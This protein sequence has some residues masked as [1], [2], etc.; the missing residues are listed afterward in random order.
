MCTLLSVSRD[1][2]MSTSEITE[3]IIKR[4]R[5]DADFNSDGF[6]LI[7]CGEKDTDALNVQ[8]MSLDSVL[9]ILENVNWTRMW[10][11]CRMSTTKITGV[12]GCHG[13]RTYEGWLVQHNGVITAGTA[14]RLPVD[15]M[16]IADI[17]TTHCVEDCVNWLHANA[18]YANVF[19]VNPDSGEWVVSRSVQGSLYMD[20]HG[21]YSTHP[22]VEAGITTL[23]PKD[24]VDFHQEKVAKSSSKYMSKYYSPLWKETYEDDF[25]GHRYHPA[26]DKNFGAVDTE[27]DPLDKEDE[28]AIRELERAYGSTCG[29][30]DSGK[31]DVSPDLLSLKIEASVEGWET[32][33]Y[34]IWQK[35]TK[36]ER[37][38]MR[39]FIKCTA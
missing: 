21:N 22:I 27:V 36:K 23:V 32:V 34:H 10:L 18:S 16:V 31:A 6:S 25:Y 33:P 28:Q 26:T 3:A 15:S 7:L 35:L 5:D 19:F 14:T 38:E 30:E 39:E 13:F 17:L 37:K 11:H 2:L 12:Q 9:A 4:I 1:F 24:F 8:L 29:T 20:D